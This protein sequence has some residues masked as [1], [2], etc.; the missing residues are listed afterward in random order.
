LVRTFIA[1]DLDGETRAGLAEAARDLRGAAPRIRWSAPETLHLT[2]KFLGDVPPPDLEDVFRAADEAAA[3]TEAFLLDVEGLRLFPDPRRPRVVSAGCAAGT[4][5]L[6]ELAAA[7]EGACAG[8]GFEPERRPFSP[9]ITLGRIRQPRD[10]GGIAQALEAYEDAVFGVIP[11]REVTVFMSELRRGGAV[12]SP[13]HRAPCRA[14]AG[15][16]GG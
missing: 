14:G 9:H 10:A 8:A 15:G 3:A 7:V 11:V 1:V 4:R 12:H 13:M 2:L 5:E 16:A 6:T